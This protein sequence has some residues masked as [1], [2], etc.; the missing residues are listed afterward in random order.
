MFV[1][2]ALALLQESKLVGQVKIKPTCT[3]AFSK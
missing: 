3:I 1:F 2:T